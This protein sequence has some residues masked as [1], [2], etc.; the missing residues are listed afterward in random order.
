MY[1]TGMI[2][3]SIIC[4][5]ILLLLTGVNILCISQQLINDEK[6]SLFIPSFMR[7]LDFLG[8]LDGAEFFIYPLIFIVI[9]GVAMLIW[10]LVII[11]LIWYGIIYTLRKFVR[12]KKKVNKALSGK[13]KPD[14][15]H[16]WERQ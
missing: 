5:M 15:T 7:K 8:S 9:I 1:E 16:E 14:H 4:G 10:P 6:P 12:F 3:T 11:A 2:I 13:D